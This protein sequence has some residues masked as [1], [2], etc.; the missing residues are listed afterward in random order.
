METPANP[1]TSSPL[2]RAAGLLLACV[3][4]CLLLGSHQ[5]NLLYPPDPVF[6]ISSRLVFWI[7]GGMAGVIGIFCLFARGGFAPAGLVLWFALSLLVYRMG[8][9]MLGVGDA[10]P[11]IAMTASDY[12]LSPRSLGVWLALAVGGA[13]GL[14]LLSVRRERE[15]AFAGFKA[16]CPG[17]GQHV[18]CKEADAGREISCPICKKG[19]VLRKEPELK[20]TCTFCKGHIQFPTHSLGKKMPCPHCKMDITLKEFAPPRAD[21]SVVVTDSQDLSLPRKSGQ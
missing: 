12:G 18:Q 8:L 11:Y 14:A 4:S 17:C 6:E 15:R 5:G 21:R 1:K 9:L 7:I 19:F 10:R 13:A 20:M 16:A 2:Q 3:G